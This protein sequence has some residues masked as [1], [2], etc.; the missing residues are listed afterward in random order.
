MESIHEVIRN[1]NKE[2]PEIG[3]GVAGSISGKSVEVGREITLQKWGKGDAKYFWITYFSDNS[4]VVEKCKKAKNYIVIIDIDIKDIEES[5]AQTLSIAVGKKGKLSEIITRVDREELSFSVKQDFFT[6]YFIK[7]DEKYYLEKINNILRFKNLKEFRDSLSITLSDWNDYG[8]YTV[9]YVNIWKEKFWLR[10]NPRSQEM[11]DYLKGTG[12]KPML[13]DGTDLCSLGGVEYYEFLKKYL[14]YTIRQ[15]WFS[16]TKDFAYNLKNLDKASQKYEDFVDSYAEDFKMQPPYGKSHNFFNNSFMRNM[17]IKKIKDIF[18]PLTVDGFDEGNDNENKVD[19]KLAIKESVDEN[20]ESIKYDF[21]NEKGSLLF[22]KNRGSELST[23]VYAIIGGN[24]SGKSFRINEIIK[25]HMEGDN[26]FSSIIHFSLS[27]FDSIIKYKQ[28]GEE[29]EIASIEKDTDG[30]LYEKI[31]FVSVETPRITQVVNKLQGQQLKDII[32]WL[33]DEYSIDGSEKKPTKKFTMKDSFT[34]YIQ[35]VLLD[36]I[37]ASDKKF[38]LWLNCLDLFAFEKWARDIIEAFRDKEFQLDDF[39][40]LSELSSGQST[41]LLY[42]T[43]L[44]S[45]INRGCLV[46][47]DEPETFMHP[48]M[49]KAFIRAVAKVCEEE[50]AFCLIATHSPLILQEIPHKCIYTL[51]AEHE[52]RSVSYKTFGENLDSLYKNV[53]GVELQM[54]GYNNL[55]TERRNFLIDSINKVAD[56]EVGENNPN[57]ESD[58]LSNTQASSTNDKEKTEE[59]NVESFPIFSNASD[60]N[61]LGDEAYLKYLIIEEEI[62]TYIKSKNNDIHPKQGE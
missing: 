20:I 10:V 31:G 57:P 38:E 24:G 2:F 61:L 56:K 33:E 28:N 22:V 30:V 54:T 42:I 13:D 49:I 32:D 47:F 46:I 62:K 15:Q 45:S 4:E 44:V 7:F 17:E 53:Y 12:K 5:S 52:L 55:L 23:E 8:Y 26:K 48:P 18:H 39:K 34:F 14:P 16:I 1:I 58:S 59:L 35:D 50:K 25:S 60:K 41:I 3:W 9:L 27:P 19:K 11:I 37:A 40:K 29:F 36:F 51:N 6:C 43:K 21:G